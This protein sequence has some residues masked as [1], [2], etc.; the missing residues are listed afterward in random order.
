MLEQAKLKAAVDNADQILI[1]AGNQFWQEQQGLTGLAVAEKLAH[2]AEHDKWQ[3]LTKLIAQTDAKTS[4][5]LLDLRAIIAD[6]PYFVATS[7]W[8]HLFENAGFDPER[9]FHL[10]GDWH[11]LQCSSG[12]NHGVQN[13][14]IAASQ[15]EPRCKKCGQPMQLQVAANPHFFPD[16][17]ANARF[18]WF[19]V[20][21]EDK[22]L[23][24]LSL[25]VD[26]T[27]PQLQVPLEDL[28]DQFQQWQLLAFN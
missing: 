17:E 19:L 5:D 3:L 15:T 28:I 14:K 25:G 27:T 16:N 12:I 9:I 24:I 6:K 18:R 26:Q 20:A 23:L 4:R 2:A 22:R 13:L 8:S 21:S 11:K 10:Q 1:A 7:I